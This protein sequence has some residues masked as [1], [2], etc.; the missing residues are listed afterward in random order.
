MRTP[1]REI[2]QLL[3]SRKSFTGNSMSA[4]RYEDG[5]YDV[6]SYNT[7]IAHVNVFGSVWVIDEN[8][9]GPTSG[10]HIN[11]ARKYL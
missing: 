5:S 4:W 8:R 10:R 11:L 7:L 3:Q 2:P 6:R 9:W 1:Y